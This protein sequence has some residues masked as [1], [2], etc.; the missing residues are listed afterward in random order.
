MTLGIVHKSFINT[1]I[2]PRR[3]VRD[4]ASHQHDK[5]PEIK[6][7]FDVARIEFGPDRVIDRV[8]TRCVLESFGPEARLVFTRK[9]FS[10][11]EQIERYWSEQ[12]QAG[13]LFKQAMIAEECLVD[14]RL[15]REIPVM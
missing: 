5:I 1:V 2:D 7:C 6:R 10:T 13:S 4:G 9:D 15:T 8:G 14:Q 3:P 11:H 12:G